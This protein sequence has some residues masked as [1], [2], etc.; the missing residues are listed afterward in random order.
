MT[1]KINSMFE[2]PVEHLFYS[3][4]ARQKYID[5]MKN[6]I[7]LDPKRGF[8]TR[9]NWH[10]A[11]PIKNTEKEKALS[12]SRQWPYHEQS[13]YLLTK[14][15]GMKICKGTLDKCER[16]AWAH[17]EHDLDNLTSCGVILWF[18]HEG[19]AYRMGGW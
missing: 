13:R 3:A 15:N 14:K 17:S 5:N 18:L 12:L 19:Q 1:D 10:Y 11:P 2:P 7:F 4:A 16:A 6:D 8:G 9:R